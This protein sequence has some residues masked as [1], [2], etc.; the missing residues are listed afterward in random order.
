ME[1]ETGRLRNINQPWGRR[2]EADGELILS[3]HRWRHVYPTGCFPMQRLI[4]PSDTEAWGFGFISC[5]C[6]VVVGVIPTYRSEH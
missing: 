1:P 2:V 3:E 6:W 5:F 4:Y